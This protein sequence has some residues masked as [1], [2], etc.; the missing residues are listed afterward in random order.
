MG[1]SQWS[2]VRR[3]ELVNRELV[4]PISGSGIDFLVNRFRVFHF[5]GT[6]LGGGVVVLGFMGGYGVLNRSYQ[7]HQS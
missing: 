2:G 6:L 7:R 1:R 5:V 4:L 3:Q